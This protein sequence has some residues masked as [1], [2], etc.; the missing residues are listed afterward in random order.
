MKIKKIKPSTLLC[1]CAALALAATAAPAPAARQPQAH[2]ARSIK[3]DDT[4]RLSLLKAFGSVLIERGSAKGTLPGEANVRMT[5]ASSVRA[6]FSI[7][8]QGGAIYGHG[9]A[10]LHSGGRYASFGGW[11]SVSSGSGRYAH[12]HGSGKLYGVIDRRTHTLTV[13]TVGTLSY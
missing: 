5:V 2:S 13:Q 10:S 4:G 8:A 1:A 12:A 3:V 6:S 9:G 11:L 7:R